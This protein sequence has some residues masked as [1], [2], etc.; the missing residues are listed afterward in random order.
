MKDLL[1]LACKLDLDQSEGKL[2]QVSASA[3]KPFTNAIYQKVFKR[4]LFKEYVGRK[5]GNASGFN[6]R[7]NFAFESTHSF[8]TRVITWLEYAIQSKNLVPGQRSISINTALR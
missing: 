2:S 6:L 7:R 8:F 1:R 3:R 5:V 4:R